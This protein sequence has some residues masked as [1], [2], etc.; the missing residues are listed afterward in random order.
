MLRPRHS[1]MSE[2]APGL[3][4]GD[5]AAAASLKALRAAGITHILNCTDQPNPLEE[6]MSATGEA[7]DACNTPEGLPVFLRLGLL[8]STADLP[9]MQEVL[10]VGVDF[11]AGAIASGGTVL[12]HC[13][14]GIS[15]SATLAMAFLIKSQQ[16][17]AEQVFETIRK[18]RR[19]IDPNLAYWCALK[20]WE[21]LVVAP[22][23]LA[24][25]SPYTSKHASTHTSVRSSPRGSVLASPRHSAAAAAGHPMNTSGGLASPIALPKAAAPAAIAATLSTAVT[26]ATHSTADLRPAAL[27]SVLTSPRGVS[28]RSGFSGLESRSPAGSMSQSQGSRSPVHSQSSGQHSIGGRF[29]GPGMGG[30]PV[31]LP[32]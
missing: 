9:R 5:E 13:H 6:Q 22:E 3:Y 16:T 12:V 25:K 28:P 11:I 24:S 32:R 17:T 10:R 4:V 15:R 20:E 27:S 31:P 18:T 26:A 23:R 7:G 1:A 8:D 19:V 29:G 30:S 14:R 21:A 2:V